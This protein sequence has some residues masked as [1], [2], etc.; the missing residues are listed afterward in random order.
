MFV[1]NKIRFLSIIAFSLAMA[2]FFLNGESEEESMVN[3]STN[4]VVYIVEDEI[5]IEYLEGE[6]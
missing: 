6:D 3:Y 5:E 2:L 4:A 1:R